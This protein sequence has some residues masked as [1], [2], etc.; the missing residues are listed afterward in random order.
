MA[1]ADAGAGDLNHTREVS[2]W[3]KVEFAQHRGSYQTSRNV[4]GDQWCD[5][6]ICGVG[7]E[8]DPE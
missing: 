7:Q 2:E 8:P 6:R 5:V 3:R 1:C 4:K